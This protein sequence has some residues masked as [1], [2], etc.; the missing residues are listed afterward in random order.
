MMVIKEEKVE[1]II[2][3]KIFAHIVTIMA[4]QWIYAIEIMVINLIEVL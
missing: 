4:I 3:E 1:E 2:L